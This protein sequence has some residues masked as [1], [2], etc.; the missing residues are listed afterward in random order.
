MVKEYLSQRGISYREKDVS[1][2]RA[3]AQEMVDRTGQMGVPVTIIDGQTIIGFDRPQLERAL[4]QSKAGATS[5][6]PP[7]R[8]TFG[9]SIADASRVSTQRGLPP[10]VGA[11]IG[12]VRPGSAAQRLGLAAE[13]IIVEV[14]MQRI[15]NSSDMERVIGGLQGGSRVSIVFLRGGRE[16]TTEGV[17]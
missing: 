13:D 2:D 11:Y 14:N 9:A 12:H 6:P 17:F 1:I 10:T 16:R 7:E 4:A 5:Q 15:T 3:A 8:P